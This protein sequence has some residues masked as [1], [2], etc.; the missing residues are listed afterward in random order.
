[1][2]W[3][4]WDVLGYLGIFW[5]IL[6]HFGTFWDVLGHLG[7]YWKG[8]GRLGMFW[9]VY[10][11]LGTS[12]DILGYFAKVDKSPLSKHSVCMISPKA[13]GARMEGGVRNGWS[14]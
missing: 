4:I 5:D 11:R 6:G 13:N 2:F 12:W 8:L 3:D 7:R 14:V 1:M 10:G 9:D